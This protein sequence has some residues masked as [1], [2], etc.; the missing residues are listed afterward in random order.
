LAGI[1]Y[2]GRTGGKKNGDFF[3]KNSAVALIYWQL[4]VTGCLLVYGLWTSAFYVKQFLFSHFN[5]TFYPWTDIFFNPQM[6]RFLNY[7]FAAS[8]LAFFYAVFFSNSAISF[9]LKNSE[10]RNKESVIL[11]TS[12][13]ILS[14]A[15]SDYIPLKLRSIVFL[16]LEMLSLLLYFS[17]LCFH[18]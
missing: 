3:R 15:L 7:L 13:I 8:G 9:L 4:F 6:S 17:P 12:L 18:G 16:A 10:K 1:T 2:D 5:V 14:L 11:L